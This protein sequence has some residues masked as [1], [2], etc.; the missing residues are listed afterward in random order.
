MKKRKTLVL[1]LGK[2]KKNTENSVHST[3]I[4]ERAEKIFKK[5]F[6]SGRKYCK[7]YRNV[8]DTNAEKGRRKG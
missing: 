3:K 7:L 2:P 5:P 8:Q 4:S 6:S 1:F